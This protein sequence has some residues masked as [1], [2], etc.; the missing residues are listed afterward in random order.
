MLLGGRQSSRSTGARVVATGAGCAAGRQMMPRSRIPGMGLVLVAPHPSP[1]PASTSRWTAPITLTRAGQHDRPVRHLMPAA[2][3]APAATP[4]PGPGRR[5]MRHWPAVRVHA[6]QAARRSSPEQ[7]APASAGSRIART[8][9][10]R[11]PGRPGILRRLRART[12]YTSHSSSA[13]CLSAVERQRQPVLSRIR[14]RCELIVRDADVLL[15]GDL[16]VGPALGTRVTSSRSRALSLPGPGADRGGP[17]S[18]SMRAYSAA[19]GRLIAAP[20]FPAAAAQ[21]RP[22]GRRALRSRSYRRRLVFRLA[23]AIAFPSRA[24]KAA[25][26]LAEAAAVRRYSEPV[27]LICAITEH[28]PVPPRGPSCAAGVCAASPVPGR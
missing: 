15:D 24:C 1:A 6:C 27:R 26:F 12:D 5:V 17:G 11:Q 9:K 23:F 8:G 18:V 22:S 10:A 2:T 19:V 4:H 13:T 20:C 21:V 7:I 3:P 25:A 16:G 14:S 28:C